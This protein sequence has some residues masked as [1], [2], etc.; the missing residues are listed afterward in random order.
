MAPATIRAQAAFTN[1]P[2]NTSNSWTAD[3]LNPPTSLTTTDGITIR[4]DWTATPDTYATGHRIYRST[5]GGGP[6]TQIAEITPRTT[7][8]YVD[9]PAA[10]TYYYI[11]RAYYLTWESV[12]SNEA[13]G[14][15]ASP[16]AAVSLDGGLGHTC[17]ARVDGSVWCWGRND[18]GQV[19]NG[20]SG[21][22]VDVPVQ[23]VGAGGV[24]VLSDAAMVAAGS[25]HSCVVK[26]DATVW[27]WGHNDEGQLGDNTTSDS[28]TPVQVVGVGGIGVLS[29]AAMVVAGEKHTC[30]VKTDATVWCWGRN[31][32]GQLGDNTTS[33]S[34]T[35]VQ[36]VGVGGIGVLSDA[37][38]VVA[39]SSHSC[40]VKT[41]ATVW[42]WGHNDEGQL[43]DNTTSD[44]DTPVQVVGAG[45]VGVLTSVA[46]AGAG[47]THTCAAPNRRHRLVLGL[48]SDAQL[49]DNTTTNNTTPS[50]HSGSDRLR[51]GLEL[52]HFW[53][54]WAHSFRFLYQMGTPSGSCTRWELLPV[55]VP[56]GRGVGPHR[57]HC[58][59]RDRGPR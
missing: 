40:V 44:S 54:L 49:G 37:A 24:G 23:V 1:A 29:D 25:S 45:G 2:D 22:D 30:V 52:R 7:T 26:T 16:G 11:A 33:D 3:T 5:T 13:T 48:N 21:A 57:L 53:R 27:C 15:A 35:P 59:D 32:K 10:G 20:V 55:P 8:T 50:K 17:G 41:D 39:G 38:M 31:D 42:C 36:V 4:L 9:S 28:D 56:D 14:T 6:Y 34:D 58:S 47:N 12:N 43:G 18:R 51:P 46:V 19:G